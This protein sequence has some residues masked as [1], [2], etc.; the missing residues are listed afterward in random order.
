VDECKPLVHGHPVA[1]GRL[2][3]CY[4]I[5]WG[6]TEDPAQAAVWYQKAADLGNAAAK[7]ALGTMLMNGD[8]RA[9]V[10]ADA[11]RGF[12][13][14]REA[15]AQGFKLAL[16]KVACCYLTGKGVEMDA[17]HGVTILRQII[18]EG[19]DHAPQAQARLAYCY[20]VGNGVEAD[21]VQASLWCQRAADG[22][23]EDAIHM[24]PMIRTCN[25]CSA[26]CG[27]A[28]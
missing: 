7:S 11:T 5:G 27:G 10:V 26:R 19:D 24:L 23:D 9:G 20:Y 16:H 28:G 18:N 3:D 4:Y 8:A 15:F 13:L 22:G 12:A 25:F 21:T 1:M 14:V 17:V 6:V 2:A